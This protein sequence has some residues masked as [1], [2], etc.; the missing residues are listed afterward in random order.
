MSKNQAN[1]TDT[2]R[3]NWETP[4]DIFNNLDRIFNFRVDLCADASNAKC[5]TYIDSDLDIFSQEAD[6]IAQGA[7]HNAMFDVCLCVKLD[8]KTDSILTCE[9]FRVPLLLK[10]FGFENVVKVVR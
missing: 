2:R 3:E 4:D 6:V 10:Q 1:H 7:K 5:P 8:E 9:N